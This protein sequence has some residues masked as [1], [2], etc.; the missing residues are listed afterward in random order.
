MRDA[1][2]KP[3]VDWKAM[4][5]TFVEISSLEPIH[6]SAAGVTSRFDVIYL[7]VNFL[8]KLFIHK[9]L[10]DPGQE[11]SLSPRLALGDESGVCHQVQLPFFIIVFYF[12]SSN[13]YHD[14]ILY[15]S[16]GL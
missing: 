8:W 13:F 12:M 14:E 16:F 3:S 2:H 1:S 5:A 7:N 15:R 11:P 10:T 4:L 6:V 9:I